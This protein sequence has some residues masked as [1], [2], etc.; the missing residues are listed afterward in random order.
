MTDDMRG[1]CRYCYWNVNLPRCKPEKMISL[2]GNCL[3]WRLRK[4]TDT[5]KTDE[6]ARQLVAYQ[7]DKEKRK[8]SRDK[9]KK[10]G[11]KGGA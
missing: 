8:A 9:R 5:E 10:Q 4:M 6:K 3:E 11:G 2:S 1:Y 7:H